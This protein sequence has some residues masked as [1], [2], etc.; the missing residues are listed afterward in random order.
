MLR[1]SHDHPVILYSRRDTVFRC[2]RT[3][4]VVVSARCAHIFAG[5]VT[6]WSEAEIIR[7][8]PV[9]EENRRLYYDSIHHGAAVVGLVLV[10][11][12]A[13]TGGAEAA[14][15]VAIGA[16]LA[17]VVFAF[18]SIVTDKFL[19]NA[20]RSVPEETARR[21]AAGIRRLP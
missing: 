5:A 17:L 8:G 11:A 15:G 19:T 20:C 7:F 14:S 16:A 4:H 10:G 18:F 21:L 1:E 9:T 3:F 13:L 6:A 12:G 2:S